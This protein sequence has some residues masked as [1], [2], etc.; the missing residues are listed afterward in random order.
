[1]LDR[2]FYTEALQVQDACNLSGVVISF[3]GVLKKL[4]EE[5]LSTDEIA[6]HPVARVWADKIASLTGI[7]GAYTR[8]RYNVNVIEAFDFVQSKTGV[9]T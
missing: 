5:G 3:A 9:A 6:N 7:Q 2:K 8:G 1:M 4:R